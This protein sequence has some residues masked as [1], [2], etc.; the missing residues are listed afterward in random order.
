MKFIIFINEDLKSTPLIF[1]IF[2]DIDFDM[3][4]LLHV[5]LFSI[6]VRNSNE[7]LRHQ[8]QIQEISERTE[9]ILNAT[10]A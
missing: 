7:L 8:K 9:I 2:K 6:S 10:I 4:M 3:P 1:F 5:Y